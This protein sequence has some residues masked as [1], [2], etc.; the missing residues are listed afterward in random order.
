MGPLDAWF[1]VGLMPFADELPAM[2]RSAV[3]VA[4]PI[5]A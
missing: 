1:E 5:Y 3:A 4:L 2:P